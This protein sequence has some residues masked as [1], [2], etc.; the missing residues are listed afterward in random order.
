M[1]NS[2][3]LRSEYRTYERQKCFVGHSRGAEW[4][5][6]ILG[7]CAE[8]LP[9]FGLEPWYAADHFDPTK[10]LRDKVV[11]LIAN[12]RYGIYDLSSWQDIS[13]EWHLPRN[14][15]IELGMAIVLNRP[16]LLLC[17][18]S[19]KA[20]PLPAC[21]Q[22]VDLVEFAGETTLKKALQQ[23]LPQW[24]DV[25]PDRDWLNRF[26][27]FG[28]RVCGFREEHPRAR[29]WGHETLR[30][31][32]CDGLD[33]AHSCC[34]KAE[35]EEIR[36]AFEG[37]F[38]R[39]SDLRFD[40]LEDLALVDG[41]QFLLCG[42]CQAVRSTSFA[43]Y[44]ILPHSPAEVF[45]AIGMSIALETLFEYDI[46]KVLLVRQ[47][48]D[49]PSLLRGYEVVEAVSSSEVKRK[50]KA[51]V[52]A[53]MQKVR[54]TAWKPRPLPFV[55]S[56]PLG[57]EEM[58]YTREEREVVS[59]GLGVPFQAPMVPPYFVPRPEIS[60]AL[61][62][63]LTTDIPSG[64]LAV[65]AIC[66][67]GGVGKTTLVAALTH[68]PVVQALFPDGVLWVT[69]G[70]QPST[71]PFLAGWIQALGDYDF[72]PAAIESASAHLRTLLHDKACLLVVDDAWQ[73]DHV[74]S[75]LVGG[76][77]CRM[78]I[79]TRDEVLAEKVGD[80]LYFLDVMTEKEALQFV[81][82]R[83]GRDLHKEELPRAR[84]VI[85]GCGL[86]PLAL[87]L[88]LAQIANGMGWDRLLLGL[89]E[90]E[91]A[92][93]GLDSLSRRGESI[94]LSLELS[95]ARLAV[96]EQGFF[97]A[98]GIFPEGFSGKEAAIV[99]ACD[100]EKARKLLRRLMQTSLIKWGGPGSGYE[101]HPL[102]SNYAIQ[103]LHE[104]GEWNTV[105]TRYIEALR[106]SLLPLLVEFEG[107]LRELV[108]QALQS[109]YGQ[110]WPTRLE[111]GQ[112]PS[113]LSL[114]QMLD[115]VR[116]QR[117]IFEPLFTTSGA[118][119]TLVTTAAEITTT[120]NA[121]VHAV[122]G[123]DVA[124]MQRVQELVERLLPM[125][126]E[127]QS[128][129]Q[130]EADLS[131]PYC[132]VVMP[133]ASEFE[134]VFESIRSAVEDS[135]Q[136]RCLRA[137]SI[138]S[139][140]SIARK[141]QRLI[142]G[143]DLV[144][145]DISGRNPNVMVEMG[146]ARGVGKPLVIISQSSEDVPFDIR[147]FPYVA[148]TPTEDGLVT[149]ES[150]LTEVLRQILQTERA[151]GTEV[152]YRQTLVATFGL[153]IEEAMTSEELPP[154]VPTNYTQLCDW[155]E[156]DLRSRLQDSIGDFQYAEASKRTGETL[157]VRI[158]FQWESQ[159]RQPDFGDLEWWSVLELAPFEDV[160]PGQDASG[161]RDK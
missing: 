86:L 153:N 125:I 156:E 115:L 129:I 154:D 130:L 157:S 97:R 148:Y 159:D 18:T 161:F 136:Y 47:E 147:T 133:F 23:R 41:Y 15:L 104:A 146:T 150:N 155:F 43:V 13:G 9:R 140:D 114:G 54:E 8:V 53:V 138:V 45:I 46:P 5:D 38:N 87:E 112:D 11:E 34:Q 79:T 17:H 158:A 4:R 142:D 81:I 20:L 111:V 118:Y 137:D 37:I 52:P 143:A 74:R 84:Q 64:T 89:E 71:V 107:A 128:A 100:E 50:L 119:G 73:A 29:Q 76:P 124:E 12:A 91:L 58:V 26:C 108:D 33:R 144:I 36:G 1:Q 105:N 123:P 48:Q 83:L 102:A 132:F 22:G 122:A 10:P 19:N 109:R 101:L 110:E 82:Q 63:Y 93:V 96:D 70:Q 60:Q 6:D 39:Y 51:F 7:A 66:G 40:Y 121:L 88:A 14:V 67:L 42:H 99:G 160:Y 56:V 94:T 16:T 85:H 77:R 59:Y 68:D 139:G 78:I 90:G 120:R 28:N 131:S 62:D 24:F 117:D 2:G 25:P 75:F 127:A 30:C 145:A 116:E 103:K 21:L 106:F 27:I 135:T 98:I 35:L 65:S 57:G 80:R 61:T 152:D 49:L 3:G 141:A 92:A 31:H 72:R 134:P 126:R 44:R 151:M 32:V 55:E 149:L 113:R 95:Y 69:L